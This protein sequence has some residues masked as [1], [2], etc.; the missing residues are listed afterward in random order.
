MAFYFYFRGRVQKVV[1]AVE[2]A[3][4]DLVEPLTRMGGGK[5]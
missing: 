4:G 2:D 5:R 1:A 3:S